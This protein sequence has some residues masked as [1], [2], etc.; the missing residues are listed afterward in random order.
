MA[1]YHYLVL[2]RAVVG[3][4][5]P[6]A[7][8]YDHQHIPDCLRVAGVTGARRFTILNQVF[9]PHEDAPVGSSGFDSLAIYEFET[10]DPVA[11]AFHLHSI[12]GTEAMPISPAFDRTATTKFLAIDA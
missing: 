4:A 9:S 7:D 11:L 8:W 6:F 2:T 1:I 10:D 3:Q 5:Q 12:A